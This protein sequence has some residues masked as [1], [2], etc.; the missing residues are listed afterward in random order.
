MTV[1]YTPEE[2][3]AA[4]ALIKAAEAAEAE[5]TATPPTP[6][7][8]ADE[9]PVAAALKGLSLAA[10]LAGASLPLQTDE[11]PVSEPAAA[12]VS[13]VSVASLTTAQVPTLTHAQAI[14]SSAGKL[15]GITSEDVSDLSRASPVAHSARVA[16]L[17]AHGATVSDTT[18]QPANVSTTAVPELPTTKIPGEHQV[19]YKG[20][21]GPVWVRH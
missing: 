6:E 9:A 15:A 19:Q 1:P 8:A 11:S 16:W 4:I 3:A 7:P 5:Q 2:L 17:Q 10:G 12:S 21:L 18:S 20:F 14:S 13:T